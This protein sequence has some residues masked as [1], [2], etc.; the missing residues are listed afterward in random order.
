VKFLIDKSRRV[1]TAVHDAT[2]DEVHDVF[3]IWFLLCHSSLDEVGETQRLDNAIE[4]D[5]VVYHP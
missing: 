5:E 1:T 3:N 2:Y 4:E